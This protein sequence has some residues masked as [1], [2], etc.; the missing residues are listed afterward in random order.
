MVRET[1]RVW[2]S[3]NGVE[4][5]TVG[6]RREQDVMEARRVSFSRLSRDHSFRADSKWDK[7]L[8]RPGGAGPGGGECCD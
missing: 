6:E 7:W 1:D 2:W 5:D 3:D 8:S 4:R